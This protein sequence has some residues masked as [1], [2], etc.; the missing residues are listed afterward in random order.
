MEA[1]ST[2]ESRTYVLM[3]M[4]EEEAKGTNGGFGN[5]K[6]SSDFPDS[7]FSKVLRRKQAGGK[8][9]EQAFS[10]TFQ[11]ILAWKE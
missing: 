2:E 4:E 10:T 6:I 11:R 5:C 1:E 8:K 9:V 3:E 7:R